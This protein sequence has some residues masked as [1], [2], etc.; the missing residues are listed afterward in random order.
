MR[1]SYV[2]QKETKDVAVEIATRLSKL[3]AESPVVLDMSGY[4]HICNYFVICTA[5]SRIHQ[6]GLRSEICEFMH[7]LQLDQ[8][9]GLKR[10][11]DG[12]AWLVLD[13]GDIVVHIMSDQVREFYELERLWFDAPRIDITESIPS[14]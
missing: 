6:D 4:S 7:D 2:D 5:R 8:E 9:R 1:P 12:D 11:K 14:A 3:R 10:K 13:F